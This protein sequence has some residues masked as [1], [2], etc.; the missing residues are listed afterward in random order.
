MVIVEEG[1]VYHDRQ[2]EKQREGDGNRIRPV[3]K[4]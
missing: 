1:R 3:L 4:I 2:E